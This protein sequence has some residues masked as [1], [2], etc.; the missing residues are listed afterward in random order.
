[1]TNWTHTLTLDASED[2]R[3]SVVG[4]AIIIRERH[5]GSRRATIIETITER[6]RWTDAGHAE[7]FAILRA[8]EVAAARGFTRIKI[9]CDCNS[10]R[11][12]IRQ[13]HRQR[14][15][16]S[17]PATA[18][19]ILRSAVLQTAKAFAHV[20]FSYIARRKNGLAHRLARSARTQE[21]ETDSVAGTRIGA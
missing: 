1:M 13:E 19:G 16:G 5:A 15:N 10:L 21:P 7:E 8:L 9:R 3:R 4:I 14:T 20:E 6:H 17:D 18:V 11:R 12:G 2:L